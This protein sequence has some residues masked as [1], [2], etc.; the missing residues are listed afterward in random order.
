MRRTGSGRL[1]L[2][3]ALAWR[4]AVVR[5]EPEPPRLQ[6]E[7]PPELVGVAAELARIPPEAF[8]PGMRLT[9]LTDP[10]PPILVV[11]A[12]PGSPA[13]RAA[14]P[15]AAGLARGGAGVVVLLPDRVRRSPDRRLLPLLQHE[16]AHVLVARAAR[17]RAVPRW[18]D[19]GLAMAAGRPIDLGDRARVALAVLSDSRL[20]LA[21]IDAAFAGGGGDVE[22]AYALAR[23]FVAQ[24]LE[25][26]GTDVGARILAQVARD[27]P[28]REAFRNVT[29]A[30]LLEVE[31]AYWRRRTFWDRWVP[32]AT[33]S[34]TLWGGITL[35]AL[36]AFRRRRLRD[37]AIHARW[38]EEERERLATLERERAA[39]QDLPN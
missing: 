28:F 7:A 10:G 11:L 21:R 13:E 1:L 19:E 37:A 9:G 24:L 3:L 6:F 8:R 20:P 25:H 35:L 34:A 39:S 36:A 23:D 29:G 16:V 31:T 32:I 33:S 17:G 5:A 30:S 2:A 15:W 18:F 38:D 27:V 14:P 22:A 12:A 4:A 26:H